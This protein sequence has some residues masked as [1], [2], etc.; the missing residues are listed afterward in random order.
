MGPSMNKVILIGVDTEE[1]IREKTRN[2]LDQF[3]A[4]A[5]G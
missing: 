1:N 2:Y 5:D 4:E 3:S